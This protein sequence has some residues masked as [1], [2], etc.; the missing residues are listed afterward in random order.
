MR[1][2][3]AL[4]FL[5]LAGCDPQLDARCDTREDCDPG[6][7]C[8]ESYCVSP[9]T[10]RIGRG[11]GAVDV[12][13][14]PDA[15]NPD[16]EPADVETPDAA[17]PDARNP[18]AEPVDGPGADAA[19]LGAADG[20]PR[21]GNETLDPGEGCDADE[22][23]HCLACE[24]QAPNIEPGRHAGV[25]QRGSFDRWRFSV[26]DGPLLARISTECNPLAVFA[27]GEDEPV[28]RAD[29]C[30]AAEVA[31]GVG[32]Y[33]I[34]VQPSPDGP[35]LARYQLELWLGAE[36]GNG[37]VEVGEDCDDG[38]AERGDGCDA[39]RDSAACAPW[40]LADD[41]ACEPPPAEECPAGAA[42]VPGG[43]TPPFEC[44]EGWI[45]E[46]Q[47]FC[48]PPPAEVCDGR[49]SAAT[50]C[51]PAWD[52]GD[53]APLPPYGCAPP[54]LACQPGQRAAIDRCTAR[55]P[56]C[57]LAHLDDPDTIYVR[58]GDSDGDGSFAAPRNAL[59]T[60]LEEMRIGGRGGERIALFPGRHV[61]AQPAVLPPGIVIVG[62]C[63]AQT[64][65][66]GSVVVVEDA[67]ATLRRVKLETG[68]R[69]RDPLVVREGAVGHLDSIWTMGPGCLDVQG[70]VDADHLVAMA[71]TRLDGTLTC[72][73]CVFG[74]VSAGLG[75]TLSIDDGTLEGQ[76]LAADN[77]TVTL[78]RV[79]AEGARLAF[80]NAEVR[81]VDVAIVAPPVGA[82]GIELA[83]DAVLTLSR[84]FV[85]ET[86]AAGVHVIEGASGVTV[87]GDALTIHQASD[88]VL[89][90]GDAAVDLTRV[91]VVAAGLHGLVL[92]AGEARAVIDGLHLA[93]VRGEEAI[94]LSGV[95]S[96][97][98]RNAVIGPR[99]GA[100]LRAEA[101][102]RVALTNVRIDG[103][104]SGIV[105]EGADIE[106]SEARIEGLLGPALE[107]EGG[108]LRVGGLVVE[109]SVEGEAVIVVRGPVEEASI[110]DASFN[111]N[112]GRVAQVV[113]GEAPSLLSLERVWIEGGDGLLVFVPEGAG[114][115]AEITLDRVALRGLSGAGLRASGAGA[116]ISGS[117]VSLVEVGGEPGYALEVRD[118]AEVSLADAVLLEGTVGAYLRDATLTLERA[119]V[120]DFETYG[121]LSVGAATLRD[122]T[123]EG[124]VEA[125]AYLAGGTAALER[126]AFSSNGAGLLYDGGVVDFVG[127][128][129]VHHAGQLVDEVDCDL[130]GEC[131]E[132]P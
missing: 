28:L 90:E 1:T 93:D 34:E 24:V 30:E 14:D 36:C 118:G 102:A 61:L 33:T 124:S 67:E 95:R 99:V 51:L 17:A 120:A 130:E 64:A 70:R 107:V 3:F 85:G 45:R 106:L 42:A 62:T 21:C 68:W 56:P 32:D 126:V 114:G 59:E 2:S 46:G 22:D 79:R 108:R 86:S 15:R 103:E 104:A 43:C 5:L 92:G 6:L 44:P 77:A 60:V 53:W 78:N 18:D 119:R 76:T 25:I 72:R 47:V 84:V 54:V 40:Y 121:L 55:L 89:V 73:R 97:T 96:T 8:D 74:T 66:V 110:A 80:A 75:A 50:T 9:P 27:A 4:S 105:A 13:A 63:P 39:C 11:D 7:V 116:G 58:T 23:P 16:A 10:G 83:D 98:L 29:G 101:G 132:A 87:R 131:P 94:R 35:R 127:P 100:A 12:G 49:P 125:G 57:E 82:P 26:A 117:A 37:E 123:L 20:A 129:L 71:P 113:G 65:I 88:G 52:C 38:N 31:V 109:G 91:S 69:G 111:G 122:V 19:D 48:R 112:A 81:L 115:T 128:P 41:G